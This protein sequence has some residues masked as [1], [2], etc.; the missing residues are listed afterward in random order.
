MTTKIASE[1]SKVSKFT[2]A[3][4]IDGGFGLDVSKFSGMEISD[5]VVSLK[6]HIDLVKGKR[7]EWLI[8]YDEDTKKISIELD[9]EE[10]ETPAEK[11]MSQKAGLVMPVGFI[12]R[13]LKEGKYADEIGKGAAVYMAAVLEYITAEVLELAGNACREENR[14]RIAP[15]HI[16]IAVQGDEQLNR[17]LGGIVVPILSSIGEKASS[18]VEDEEVSSPEEEE[19]NDEKAE[20]LEQRIREL[21]TENKMLKKATQTVYAVVWGHFDDADNPSVS[22][23]RKRSDAAKFV[24]K[25]VSDVDTTGEHKGFKV[26]NETRWDLNLNSHFIELFETTLN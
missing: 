14:S 6:H 1:I 22:I 7:E 10:S 11:T 16:Q 4:V 3:P 21:E 2:G 9:P 13:K 12:Y 24:K 23:F 17:L 20:T 26:G 25:I 15:R 18:K 8:D 19:I 5:I